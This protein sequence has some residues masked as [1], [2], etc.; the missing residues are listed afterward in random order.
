MRPGLKSNS[1]SHNQYRNFD[2]SVASLFAF[3][4]DQPG[5]SA[6]VVPA[7]GSWACRSSFQAKSGLRLS[8][9]GLSRGQEQKSNS[10]ATS[11]CP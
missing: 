2:A 10:L 7:A 8:S 9:R 1:N 3:V 6:G 11:I 5:L 4:L